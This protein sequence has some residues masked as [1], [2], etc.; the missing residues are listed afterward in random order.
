MKHLFARL[1]LTAT[2]VA[3][4]SVLTPAPALAADGVPAIV[5]LT[6]PGGSSNIGTNATVCTSS[7]VYSSGITANAR[8]S[9]KP[10]AYQY[11]IDGSLAT[12]GTISLRRATGGPVY[13]TITVATGTLA[14]VAFETN[15]FYWLRNDRIHAT[16]SFTNTGNITVMGNEQ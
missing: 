2:I 11:A 7:N 9:F 4:C 14:S 1:L 12:A 15:S 16:A 13:A 8:S 5:S 10:V 3:A 6:L